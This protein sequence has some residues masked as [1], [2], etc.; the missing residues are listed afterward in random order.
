MSVFS[1]EHALIVTSQGRPVNQRALEWKANRINHV[2]LCASFLT[3]RCEV[4]ERI[5]SLGCNLELCFVVPGL[6]E[7]FNISAS[8]MKI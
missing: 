6:T 8:A 5:R 1:H 3:R 4:V 2:F 7:Y